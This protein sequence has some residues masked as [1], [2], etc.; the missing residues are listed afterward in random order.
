MEKSRIEE[1]DVLIGNKEPKDWTRGELDAIDLRA[2]ENASNR[3]PQQIIKNKLAGIEYR[4]EDNLSTTEN[5]ID[6]EE[7]VNQFLV[8]LNISKKEFAKSIDMDSPNLS[9]YLKGERKFTSNLAMKLGSF[10]H[11]NP[12][13]WMKIWMK[14]ELIKLKNEKSKLD[15]YKKYDYEK[16]ISY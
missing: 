10:F 4:L 14:N 3:T 16:V 11:I 15:E 13:I 8:V 7:T 2:K 9:K 1:F 5:T 12:E 6:L